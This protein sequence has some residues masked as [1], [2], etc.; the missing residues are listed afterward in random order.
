[1]VPVEHISGL[2]MP[3][4]ALVRWV[5]LTVD[6]LHREAFLNLFHRHK[7][8]IRQ[9]PCCLSMVLLEGPASGTFFTL[10]T[11][12][13]ESD[14]DAYRTSGLFAEI[15]PPIKALFSAPA[16]AWSVRPLDIPA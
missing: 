2:P 15:W 4:H 8:A 11:W 7:T 1:M 12:E 10:S 5:Q 13:S 16:R 3:P 14:L 9:F 6:P